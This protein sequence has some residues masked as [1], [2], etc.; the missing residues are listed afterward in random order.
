MS[1]T[2]IYNI[3]FVFVSLFSPE[4]SSFEILVQASPGEM[5][6]H[7]YIFYFILFYFSLLLR[8]FQSNMENGLRKHNKIRKS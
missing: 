3:F 7:L 8:P 5:S 2:I 6:L 1:S 4:N